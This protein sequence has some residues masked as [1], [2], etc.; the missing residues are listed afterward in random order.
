[1]VQEAERA[2]TR[3]A[4]RAPRHYPRGCLDLMVEKNTLSG[5]FIVY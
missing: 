3:I 4:N 5:L 1:V 2:P